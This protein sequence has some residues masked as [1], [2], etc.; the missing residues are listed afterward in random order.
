MAHIVFLFGN[1][2]LNYCFEKFFGGLIQ[3]YI[4]HE[5][6]GRKSTV[7]DAGFIEVVRLRTGFGKVIV[8]IHCPDGKRVFISW[9]ET[10]IYLIA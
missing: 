9:I 4:V 1:S 3:Y 5:Q 6:K 8:I 10:H 2:A 7:S